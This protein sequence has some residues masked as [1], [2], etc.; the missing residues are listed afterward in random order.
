M[1][2]EAFLTQI[3]H[4][5]NEVLERTSFPDSLPALHIMVWKNMDNYQEFCRSE[6]ILPS[7][8]FAGGRLLL[9]MG[10]S[11]RLLSR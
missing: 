7:I 6:N 8:P 3:R 10:K 5:A 9:I 1:I 11:K 2:D 4:W